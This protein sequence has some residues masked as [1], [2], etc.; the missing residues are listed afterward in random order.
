M[1]NKYSIELDD[2][3]NSMENENL[4]KNSNIEKYSSIFI[5]EI[6]DFE[7]NWQRM[8]IN[9]FLAPNERTGGQEP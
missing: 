6:Q 9:N 2:K 5:D 8:I 1:A 3:E 7:I 4:F